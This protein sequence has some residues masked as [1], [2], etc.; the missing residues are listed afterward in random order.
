[1]AQVSKS[2][3]EHVLNLIGIIVTGI[4]CLIIASLYK[5]A[6]ISPV[7]TPMIDG[8]AGYTDVDIQTWLFN[9]DKLIYILIGIMIAFVIVRYLIEL[10]VVSHE[11]TVLR[12]FLFLLAFIVIEII[13]LFNFFKVKYPILEGDTVIMFILWFGSLLMTYILMVAFVPTCIKFLLFPRN[14]FHK[15]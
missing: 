8:K 2:S 4:I 13:L 7:V 3:L 9:F 12:T 10:T 11:K 5:N 14:L 15:G 1:M 6:K